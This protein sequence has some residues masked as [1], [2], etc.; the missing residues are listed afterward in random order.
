M[1]RKIVF[2]VAVALQLAFL[3]WMVAAQERTLSTGLRVPLK[4]TSFDANDFQRGRYIRIAP[5]IAEIDPGKVEVVR[6]GESLPSLAGRVA[7]V[8]LDRDG[9]VWDARRVVIDGSGVAPRLPFLRARVGGSGETSLHLDYPFERFDIPA[10]GR[11]PSAWYSDPSHALVAVVRVP[12]DGKGVLEDL[13]VDGR[14]WKT[15]NA[16]EKAKER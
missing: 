13:L 7:F 10:D 8:E 5:A 3:G 11:D 12:S 14:P 4:V 16:E 9:D 6:A 15:W 1:N 2:Q